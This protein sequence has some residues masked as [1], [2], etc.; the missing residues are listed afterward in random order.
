MKESLW[1]RLKK[2]IIV[3]ALE[4]HRGNQTR[5]ARY[6]E[7]TRKTLI[8]RMEKFGVMPPVDSVPAGTPA[9]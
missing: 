4:R 1:K 3:Q 6:L 2:E 7:I 8:H 5:K 9:E